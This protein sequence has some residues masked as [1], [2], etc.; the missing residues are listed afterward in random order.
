M[1][2]LGCLRGLVA[3]RDHYLRQVVAAWAALRLIPG[4]PHIRSA[5]GD[6]G[7]ASLAI[8][9]EHLARDMATANAE[10]QFQHGTIATLR[11]EH[12]RDLQQLRGQLADAIPPKISTAEELD[13]LPNRS[14]VLDAYGVPYEKTS[15]RRPWVCGVARFL[16]AEIVEYAPLT[17]V[18][19][20]GR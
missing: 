6:S 12:E 8:N 5:A 1:I 15:T 2:G 3:S 14:V 7:A 13:A 18:W 11:V 10:I 4:Y 17:V 9:I 16:S 20:P 19:R